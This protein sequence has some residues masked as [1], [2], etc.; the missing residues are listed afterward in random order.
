MPN[1]PAYA[2]ARRTSERCG[3]ICP[4]TPSEGAIAILATQ[5]GVATTPLPGVLAAK[6]CEAEH[7]RPPAPAT[8][9]SWYSHSASVARTSKCKLPP[10]LDRSKHQKWSTIERMLDCMK[11]KGRIGRHFVRLTRSVHHNI[12]ADLH[13][14]T[15]YEYSWRS[16][17]LLSA[18]FHGKKH[19]EFYLPK[20]QHYINSAK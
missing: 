15:V 14:Y 4:S 10:L 2:A 19:G 18:S 12:P 16:P 11:Q 3:G 9:C 13:A 8:G 17:K 5:C 1:E 6:D 7:Q 20:H